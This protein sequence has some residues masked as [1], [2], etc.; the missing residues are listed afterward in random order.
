MDIL[1]KYIVRI[2]TALSVLFNVLL[3]GY[4]HQSF[5]ARNYG[6]KRHGL[7]NLVWL[8]DAVVWLDP[9][10]CARAWDDWVDIKQIEDQREMKNE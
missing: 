8:I 4:N 9:D 1:F 3:G 10:H 2:I 6:W 5:S 7:L